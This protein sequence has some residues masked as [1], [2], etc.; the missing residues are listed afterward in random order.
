MGAGLMDEPADMTAPV[1]EKMGN[2]SLME[3][4]KP[5][6]GTSEPIKRVATNENEVDQ[7]FDAQ[8]RG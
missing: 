8:D 1:N 4:L 6:D 3:P 2:L 5:G 7:F